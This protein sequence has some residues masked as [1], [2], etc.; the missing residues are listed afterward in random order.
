M[1]FKRSEVLPPV[2]I[3]ITIIAVVDHE[4]FAEFY[5]SP[6][7]GLKRFIDASSRY[8]VAGQYCS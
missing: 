8:I 4:Q 1:E 7:L 6:I 5:I 2:V 3:L